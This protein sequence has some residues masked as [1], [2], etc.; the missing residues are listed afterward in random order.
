MRAQQMGPGLAG[1]ARAGAPPPQWWPRP[2][3]CPTHPS[4]R[5]RTPGWPG[6][7]SPG[8]T[9]ACP[10]SRAPSPPHPPLPPPSGPLLRRRR[11]AGAAGQ[12]GHVVRRQR[13][14]WLGPGA[15]W[16]AAPGSEL[17]G[18]LSGGGR[19]PGDGG[20]TLRGPWESGSRALP[21]CQVQ[22]PAVPDVP[23]LRPHAPR[24]NLPGR[25][26][27]SRSRG[28]R[29]GDAGGRQ[30]DGGESC[31][32]GR[33]PHSQ[34]PGEPRTPHTEVPSGPRAHTRAHTRAPC[35][36]SRDEALPSA[37]HPIG[38]WMDRGAQ[39]PPGEREAPSGLRASAS[40]APGPHKC[41]PSVGP[42][43]A[44]PGSHLPALHV[45]HV[46]GVL[47]ALALVLFVLLL[48]AA[49]LLADAEAAGDEQ[50]AGDH[51]DGDQRPR[52]YCGARE[53]ASPPRP[54][55]LPEPSDRPPV[56][57]T[58]LFP[59]PLPWGHTC[60]RTGSDPG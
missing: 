58:S 31:S 22:A 9:A 52:G 5:V 45:L 42:P 7:R 10:G 26:P 60:H 37:L 36:A 4:L 13:A 3:A 57:G 54:A 18:G 53:S 6:S 47:H 15:M 35:L 51:G 55:P 30:A 38:S 39:S 24:A 40:S 1:P 44:W 56:T 48:L 23:Q 27:G 11:P 8:R 34:P 12:E 50:E 43:R 20:S 17:R 59:A 46:H 41:C 29:G 32:C 28:V 33:P 49:A 21:P 14:A 19:L 25:G 2:A 16:G